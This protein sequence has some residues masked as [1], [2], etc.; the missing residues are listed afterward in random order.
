[1]PRIHLKTSKGAK[2]L[3]EGTIG[4]DERHVLVLS[5][6]DGTRSPAELARLSSLNES[7]IGDILTK[8][9]LVG[10]ARTTMVSA[11][12][13]GPFVIE[14]YDGGPTTEEDMGA[15][16]GTSAAPRKNRRERI[17]ARDEALESSQEAVATVEAPPPEPEIDPEEGWRR[18]AELEAQLLAERAER[19]R[20]AREA[21]EL[22]L[23]RSLEREA[24]AERRAKEA[25]ETLERE[26]AEAEEAQRRKDAQ[27][28][29]KRE[30]H[31][32]ERARQRRL[33]IHRRRARVLVACSGLAFAAI[34][35][36]VGEAALK[37]DP[38]SCSQALG[39]WSGIAAT[40][41]SCEAHLFPTP[42]FV[43]KGVSLGAASVESATGSLSLAEALV[44][45]FEPVSLALS[46][47]K[48]APAD[49]PMLFA[50]RPGSQAKLRQVSIENAS[51][52]LGPQ[53]LSG[54][55]GSASLRPD[56]GLSML[57]LTDSQGWLRL[58][59]HVGPDGTPLATVSA[60]FSDPSLSPIP[61]VTEIS[62]SG[63]I[64]STGLS[65][66][67]GSATHA[68]G[69][70]RFTG[71]AQ[72]A[73]SW[74][75]RLDFA[76][77][78][79]TLDLAAL[80]PWIFAAGRADMTGRAEARGPDLAS[81]L[82]AG[83]LTANFNARDAVVKLDLNGSLGAAGSLGQ[84]SFPQAK[85]SILANRQG[86]TV[87]LPSLVS[88]PMRSSARLQIDPQGRVSGS[89]VASMPERALSAESYVSGNERSLA[90]TPKKR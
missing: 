27:I 7:D 5:F 15:P 26:R 69:Y 61:G 20:L 33:G 14:H 39:R 30:A 45:R 24:E 68:S 13:D 66:Q 65:I 84:T 52:A 38:S 51:I 88:G 47:A 59:A 16:L 85:G 8:L 32:L 81:A 60:R 10:Y 63:L 89:A 31:D 82:A 62:A 4:L 17:K 79:A 22:E 57:E 54:L 11:P 23:E 3:S 72:W 1:M 67:E 75:V 18:A 49:A 76:S 6:L 29:A 50:S 12:K 34:V 46:G 35:A 41:R 58:G 2:S 42:S 40:A 21:A 77:S 53:T 36:L 44:G 9:Q 37:I 43:A 71:Q 55:R 28:Q 86:A 78:A 19:E 80:T 56:G 70:A 83:T 90:L 25:L 48:L 64:T 73:P 87:S 74:S